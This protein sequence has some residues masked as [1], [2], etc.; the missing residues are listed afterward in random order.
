MPAD[1]SAASPPGA[2]PRAPSPDTPPDG[3]LDTPAA[4]LRA[5]R[6]RTARTVTALMLREMSTTYGRSPGGYLWALLEPIGAITVLSIGFSLV[7]RAPSLGTNFLLFFATGYLPF[8]LFQGVSNKVA[9]SIRFSKA[10][11]AYPAVTFLDT[12]LARFLLTLLTQTV[13]FV[14]VMTGIH[15]IYDLRTIL[16]PVAILAGLGMAAGLGLGIGTLNCYLSTAYPVWEQIWM[17]LTRPLFIAS[18]VFFTY[19]AMPG[20]VRDILWYN[21]VLQ[22]VGMVRRG[23]YA[24]YDAPYVSV[25]YVCGLSL[26]CGTLGLMLLY[27]HSRSLAGT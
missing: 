6:H 24:S 27:R 13:V 18:G 11:L 15:V 7:L 16:D 9:T 26:I 3:L 19:D 2:S 17:I 8:T 5:R 4:A 10:L 12:L 20:M 22:V 21:P 14:L 25:P 1:I 23:F